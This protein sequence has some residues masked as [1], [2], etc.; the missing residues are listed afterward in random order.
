MG[1]LS[2]VNFAKRGPQKVVEDDIDDI[3]KGEEDKM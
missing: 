1:S 3:F 2:V